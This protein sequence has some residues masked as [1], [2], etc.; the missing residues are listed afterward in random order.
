MQQDT[1]MGVIIIVAPRGICTGEVMI[2]GSILTD[3]ILARYTTTEVNTTNG[4]GITI[5]ITG[6]VIDLPSYRC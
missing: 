4:T 6:L 3:P 5:N 1:P 2:T